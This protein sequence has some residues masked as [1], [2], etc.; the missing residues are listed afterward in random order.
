VAGRADLVAM[1]HVTETGH[2]DR[3]QARPH[4]H[5]AH[6]LQQAEAARAVGHG[7]HGAHQQLPL[8]LEVADAGSG[9]FTPALSIVS[10]PHTSL[11][12]PPTGV[13]VAT[14]A[15]DEKLATTVT[16]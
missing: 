14:K 5:R 2:G 3:Q 13:A 8:L 12:C 15:C 7:I 6:Q 11:A 16:E 1:D 9:L 4:G 10:G